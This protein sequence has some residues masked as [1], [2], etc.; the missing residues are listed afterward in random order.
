METVVRCVSWYIQRYMGAASRGQ[1]SAAVLQVKTSA[2]AC[3][4]RGKSCQVIQPT[5]KNFCS[6][7]GLLTCSSS[8]IFGLS[9]CI[10]GLSSS[11]ETFCICTL[12]LVQNSNLTSCYGRSRRV[13][14]VIVR[15]FQVC[16]Q[17]WGSSLTRVYTLA[18]PVFRDLC[19]V[20]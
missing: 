1:T 17:R 12:I 7:M 9:T 13:L 15:L 10:T 3:L 4:Q 14:I 20:V 11:N 2:R 18:L 16:L 19:S 6:R 5:A 8:V